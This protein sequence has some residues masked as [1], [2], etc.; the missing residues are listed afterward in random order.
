MFTVFYI[1][2]EL[3]E[4][5]KIHELLGNSYHNQIHFEINHRI[6]MKINAGETST[7]VNIKILENI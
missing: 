7:K 2:R 5:V 6:R 3:V 1:R 4:N